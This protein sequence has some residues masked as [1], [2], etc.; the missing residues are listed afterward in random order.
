MKLS[1]KYLLV[2]IAALII[3]PLI[4]GRASYVRL[5]K[6]RLDTITVGVERELGHLQFALSRFFEDV[7]NDL[8]SLV[9]NPTI[10]TRE[11]I[12]FTSFLDAN[13][14]TFEYDYSPLEEEIITIFNSFRISHPYVN[15]VYMGRENGSFVRSHPRAKP[16]E[17]DPRDRPWY[18]ASKA[19]KGEIVR[20]YP[21]RSVTTSDINLGI[22]TTL[23]DSSEEVFG[24]VGMDITLVNLS[25]YISHCRVGRNGQI[26]LTNFDGIILGCQ[27]KQFLFSKIDTLLGDKSAQFLENENGTIVFNRGNGNNYLFYLSDS[28]IGLKVGV[29]IPESQIDS[30]IKSA[31]MP[32]IFEVFS[33]MGL[34]CL[35][36]LIGLNLFVLKPLDK[37]TDS[38]TRITQTGD[39]S[40]RV[41]I[42]SRDE[43]GNLGRSFNT[44]IEG[45][46]KSRESLERTENEL[47]HHK[48]NLEILVQERTAELE[49]SREEALESMQEAI[50]QKKIAEDISNKLSRSYDRL[51]KLEKLRDDLT[52]MIIHDMRNPLTAILS[53]ID[54]ISAKDIPYR[55]KREIFNT[56]ET[57][58]TELS[59]MVETLLDVTRLEQG[60]MPVKLEKCNILELLDKCMESM[61]AIAEYEHVN[62][63]KSGDKLTLKADC[64]LTY[65]I[66]INLLSNAIRYSSP[67]D[68][69]K[70]IVTQEGEMALIEVVDK[71]PGI[72]EKYKNIIFEKFGHV[73]LRQLNVKRSIGLGLAF[74]KM[75][76]QAQNGEI[77]VR[78]EVGDG[79][80]FWFTLPLYPENS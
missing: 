60:R 6:Q 45:L 40:S 32:T 56:L 16:T 69:V 49:E 79:S 52:N 57:S 8:H 17:Y 50:K 76:V 24:V 51:Q 4:V 12:D 66:V 28:Y 72:P 74:C 80:T 62:L 71:G 5:K 46:Q 13:E 47:R 9:M 39:L 70:A 7:Q 18:K 68:T 31:V 10:R 26:I 65:R 30:E 64:N 21:Y 19:N 61:H 20:T 75:A 59:M 22:V 78:S 58:S 23:L 43:F 67:E 48:E 73:D 33:G 27:K 2:G 54:L 37:L 29:I 55:A 53:S 15:S 77:G 63:Y 42:D 25:D 14:E 41:D 1:A 36:L 44:M 11:D 3:L 38:T 34:V 35:I